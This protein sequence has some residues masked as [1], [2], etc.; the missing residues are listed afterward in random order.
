MKAVLSKSKVAIKASTGATDPTVLT[1][2]L[3]IPNPPY[4]NVEETTVLEGGAVRFKMADLGNLL[5]SVAELSI[6]AESNTN[7]FLN[8]K[9]KVTGVKV[10]HAFILA[11]NKYVSNSKLKDAKSTQKPKKQVK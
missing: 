4:N 7:I 8:V 6:T 10:Q 3:E 11:G 1:I 2:T 9:T 5:D